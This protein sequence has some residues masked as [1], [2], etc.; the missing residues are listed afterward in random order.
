MGGERDPFQE[1]ADL[2]SWAAELG[3][4]Y[5][6]GSQGSFGQPIKDMSDERLAA[7]A[8][9]ITSEL[10]EGAD[11]PIIP[12]PTEQALHVTRAELAAMTPGQRDDWQLK[13]LDFIIENPKARITD[14]IDD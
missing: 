12:S 7:T 11:L 5:E 8:D 2:Q 3:T 14:L 13:A 4:E 1:E 10:R 6:V 9:S